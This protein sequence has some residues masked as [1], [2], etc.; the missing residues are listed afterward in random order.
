[1]DAVVLVAI[2][3]DMFVSGIPARQVKFLLNRQAIQPNTLA[4]TELMRELVGS[5]GAQWFV[6]IGH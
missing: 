3:D 6:F 1:M 5:A 4:A 2:E